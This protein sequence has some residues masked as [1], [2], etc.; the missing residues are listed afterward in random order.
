ME[1]ERYPYWGVCDVDGCDDEARDG[2]GC[3]RET[4]YRSV[5]RKHFHL[6]RDGGLQPKM[7]ESAIAKE[8]TRD[9]VTGY[10][11]NDWGANRKGYTMKTVEE[12]R[13]KIVELAREIDNWKA[14]S[15][16][17]SEVDL[18]SC[19]RV[20]GKCE[21]KIAILKWVLNEEESKK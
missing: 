18:K 17:L 13:E 3:W 12:I 19:F 7:K 9:P 16:E 20:I 21:S 1:D 10:L 8:A 4:G 2:G 6:Y 15:N 14:E 5:C 11:P